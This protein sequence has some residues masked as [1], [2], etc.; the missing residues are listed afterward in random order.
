MSIVVTGATGHL[1]HLIVEDLLAHGTPPGEVMAGGRRVERLADLAE[2]G[3]RTT[4]IDYSDPGSLA[5]AMT[6]ADAV[7][8]VSGNEIGQ[9]VDQHR[10]VIDAA[11]SAGVGRIVYTSAPRADTSPLVVAPEHKATEELIR[12]SGLTFTILRNNW[13]TE[14]YAS[15]VEQAGRSGVLVSSTGGGRVASAPR[16]DYAAAASAVLRSPGHDGATYELGGDEPWTHDELAEAIGE[17]I[18]RPVVHR[19]VSPE[20]H[21]AILTTAGLDEQSAGFVVAMDADIRAGLLAGGGH[22]LS[23]L[24]GRPTTSLTEGLRLAVGQG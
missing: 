22:D 17:V 11:R 20:E 8:L 15:A 12:A 7:A 4:R 24:I 9:R 5:E 13:Y 23:E 3:V 21:L 14:N 18:G 1:G 10:A 6:G 19:D 16:A 2:R